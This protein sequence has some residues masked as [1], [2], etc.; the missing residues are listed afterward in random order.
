M[1][2]PHEYNFVGPMGV[3]VTR[4]NAN[5]DMYLQKK[6]F[7]MSTTKA[8]TERKRFF[9]RLMD[10]RVLKIFMVCVSPDSTELYNSMPLIY[11]VQIGHN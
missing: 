8:A 10:T 9:F 3:K 6:E 7:F 11:F 2:V 4:T 1:S 5:L